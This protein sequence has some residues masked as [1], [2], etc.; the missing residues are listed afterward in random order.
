M[1]V[2]TYLQNRKRKELVDIERRYGVAIILNG[3]SA[4]IPGSGKLDF[5]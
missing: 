1:D 2:V 4:L 5:S 3:D